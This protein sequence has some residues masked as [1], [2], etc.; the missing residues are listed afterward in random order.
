MF[1]EHIINLKIRDTMGQLLSFAAFDQLELI[2]PVLNN[3]TDVTLDNARFNMFAPNA[4]PILQRRL[5][6]LLNANYVTLQFFKL[7]PPASAIDT[8]QFKT[9]A[10]NFFWKELDKSYPE[11]MQK[12]KTFYPPEKLAQEIAQQYGPL[13]NPVQRN[14]FIQCLL[15]QLVSGSPT[16]TS[17]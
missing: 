13:I 2:L 7:N 4:V 15:Q 10:Y 9:H 16:I 5:W 12:I 6:G 11:L 17:P 3:S 1:S 8:M 14:A